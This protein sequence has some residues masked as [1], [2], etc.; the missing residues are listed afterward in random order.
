MSTAIRRFHRDT[1]GSLQPNQ[2]MWGAVGLLLVSLLCREQIAEAV[3]LIQANRA[4]VFHIVVA[5]VI[6]FGGSYLACS[7]SSSPEQ[8]WSWCETFLLIAIGYLLVTVGV[9]LF[10]EALQ[11][12]S[13]EFFRQLKGGQ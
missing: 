7:S 1:K 2:A 12:R 8:A 9:P 10:M 3:A 11:A 5:L 13:D 4:A 6:L